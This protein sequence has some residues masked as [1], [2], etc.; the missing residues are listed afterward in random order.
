MGQ[1]G[2][3]G[4]QGQGQGDWGEHTLQHRTRDVAIRDED[5]TGIRVLMMLSD[6][7]KYFDLTR[8]QQQ[9]KEL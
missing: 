1:L 8:E 2:C 7:T 6:V 3:R 5:L 4:A 9:G